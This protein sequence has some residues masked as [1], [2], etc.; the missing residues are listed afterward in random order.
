MAPLPHSSLDLLIA[1]ALAGL[2]RLRHRV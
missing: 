2:G 1:S